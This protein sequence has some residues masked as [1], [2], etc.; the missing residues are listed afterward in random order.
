MTNTYLICP[1]KGAKDFRTSD[2]LGNFLARAGICFEALPWKIPSLYE[3]ENEQHYSVDSKDRGLE[4]KLGRGDFIVLNTSGHAHSRTYFFERCLDVPGRVHLGLDSH[5]DLWNNCPGRIGSNGFNAEILN[6]EGVDYCIMFGVVPNQNL[7]P[8]YQPEE[9]V[10]NILGRLD[11]YLMDD[12]SRLNSQEEPWMQD[13]YEK[14]KSVFSK[15]EGEEFLGI[16]EDLSGRPAYLSIDLDIVG[17]FPTEWQGHG[18]FDIEMLAKSITKIGNKYRVIAGDICGI[19]LEFM[20][21]PGHP[22]TLRNPLN[23]FARVYNSL[24][25]VVGH[26]ANNLPIINE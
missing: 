21:G 1:D 26:P 7:I 8:K 9:H 10:R 12:I 24:K 2:Y 15:S 20:Q 13:T 4:N 16:P 23:D 14:I 25:S 6:L 22:R 17:D 5:A 3:T 18:R 11:I 19:D